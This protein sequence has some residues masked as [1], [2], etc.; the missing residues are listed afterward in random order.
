M[1]HAKVMGLERSGNNWLQFMLRKYKDLIRWHNSKDSGWK[2]GPYEVPKHLGQDV[3]V[4]LIVKHPL[5]WIPSFFRYW[6]NAAKGREKV[7]LL[8]WIPKYADHWNEHHRSF[9]QLDLH[10]KNLFHAALTEDSPL[11]N[12]F[13]GLFLELCK[14]VHP[15]PKE[16][17]RLSHKTFIERTIETTH[18]YD[19]KK[20]K[21]CIKYIERVHTTL[22]LLI[23]EIKA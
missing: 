19:E 6:R 21:M 16:L 4:F 5:C 22:L 8:Q 11:C 17:E 12:R 1:I 14:I 2:H 10:G 9:L 18:F 15:S 20:L 13:H 23:N 3:N 7:S